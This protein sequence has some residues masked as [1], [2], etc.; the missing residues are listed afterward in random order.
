MQ[1]SSEQWR[2]VEAAPVYAVAYLVAA[3]VFWWV[4]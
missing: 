4:A 3:G 1:L 2:W